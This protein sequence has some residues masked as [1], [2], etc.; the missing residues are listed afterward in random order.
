MGM[1]QCES[2]FDIIRARLK[3]K[4]DYFD[5]LAK[6]QIK[7]TERMINLAERDAI[8][9]FI[10]QMDTFMNRWIRECERIHG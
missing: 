8:G 2:M 4:Y 3:S 7:Y 5:E 1:K 10:T 9:D 6:G